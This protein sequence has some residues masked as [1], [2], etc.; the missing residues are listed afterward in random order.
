MCIYDKIV[1][2]MALR[3]V[4]FLFP[5]LCINVF[6]HGMKDKALDNEQDIKKALDDY[7][8]GLE[9]LFKS[10]TN[11]VLYCD[12][13]EV[14]NKIKE[15]VNN[16]MLFIKMDYLFNVE[17][18]LCDEFLS[19][20]LNFVNKESRLYYKLSDPELGYFQ[21]KL[22]NKRDHSLESASPIITDTVNN[23]PNIEKMLK[24]RLLTHAQDYLVSKGILKPKKTALTT[25]IKK[26]KKITPKVNIPRQHSKPIVA[27]TLQSEQS[28]KAVLTTGIDKIKK[29]VTK[30]KIPTKYYKPISTVAGTLA[31]LG[32]IGGIS[33]EVGKANAM[34]NISKDIKDSTHTHM[35][36]FGILVIVCSM[37][38]TFAVCVSIVYHI[39]KKKQ[40]LDMAYS[41]IG[42]R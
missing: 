38:A 20:P 9:E 17:Y 15:Y 16:Q 26:M 14:V 11:K 10:T 21:S 13:D 36:L 4:Y 2:A 24:T 3:I 7:L 5:L 28:D 23:D 39:T 6:T 30:F 40:Q 37:V 22:I 35:T 25:G 18:N 34:K 33:Y 29:I 8:K 27:G 19:C 1:F 41:V 12:T 32:T 42:L 31:G